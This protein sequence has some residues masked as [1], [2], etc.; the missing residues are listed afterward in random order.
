MSLPSTLSL[1]LTACN[2]SPGGSVSERTPCDPGTGQCA[3][4]PHVTGRDCHF[5]SP[6]FYD[7]QPGR[8]CRRWAWGHRAPL[9]S[10]G[11]IGL[12]AQSGPEG[13]PGGQVAGL[14]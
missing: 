1:S 6:G 3:C 10:G 8:G 9:P 11:C 7:L 5:C 13:R 2:C 14:V 4:L 12:Q